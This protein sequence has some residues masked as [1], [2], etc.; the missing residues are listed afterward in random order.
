MCNS[1][2]HPCAE[3]LL[4]E[5]LGVQQS[6]GQECKEG[7]RE[8]SKGEPKGWNEWRGKHDSGFPAEIANWM[9]LASF[10]GPTV[11]WKLQLVG[12]V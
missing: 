1:L 4:W 9:L 2:T 3:S 5:A 12:N 6:P 10:G 8:G 11:L 7:M